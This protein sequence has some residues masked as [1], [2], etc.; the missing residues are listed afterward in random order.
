MF[1]HKSGRFISFF[2]F[3]LS[4]VWFPIVSF[5]QTLSSTAGWCKLTWW[6]LWC[7][8]G[9]GYEGNLTRAFVSTLL[10]VE[11]VSEL[12]WFLYLTFSLDRK[13]SISSGG[14]LLPQHEKDPDPTSVSCGW[15]G[16]WHPSGPKARIHQ[17][18]SSPEPR[19]ISSAVPSTWPSPQLL[20][21]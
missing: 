3:I 4:T 9:A 13:H 14:Q 21:L 12:G 15:G 11:K 2:F 19:G 8:V 6:T 18:S 16:S 10:L 20:P 1:V 7:A 5:D 17:S